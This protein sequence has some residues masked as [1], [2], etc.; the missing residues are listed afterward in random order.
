MKK[1]WVLF[2]DVFCGSDL[3]IGV[4]VCMCVVLYIVF[5]YALFS[6]LHF[7]FL[8]YIYES[9]GCTFLISCVWSLCVSKLLLVSFSTP[10]TTTCHHAWGNNYW[11]DITTSGVG[12]AVGE[13]YKIIRGVKIVSVYLSFQNNKIKVTVS[14]KCYDNFEKVLDFK[15]P[16]CSECCM[17]SSG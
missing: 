10:L 15:L 3:F 6:Y 5:S 17:L 12:G 16:L 13:I 8:I 4:C 1:R 2:V 7:I 11:C 14:F 9:A